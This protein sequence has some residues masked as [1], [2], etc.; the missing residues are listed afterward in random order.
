MLFHSHRNPF[1]LYS[2]HEEPLTVLRFEKMKIDIFLWWSHV[3]IRA[4][5]WTFNRNSWSIASNSSFKKRSLFWLPLFAR[6][7]VWDIRGCV[8]KLRRACFLALRCMYHKRLSMQLPWRWLVELILQ[9]SEDEKICTNF[10]CNN[11]HIIMISLQA[12]FD[13]PGDLVA[14]CVCDACVLHLVIQETAS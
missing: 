3:D 4:A 8:W 9:H 14:R 11:T 5:K 10:S 1:N 12:P 6:R 13:M 2:I 7:V